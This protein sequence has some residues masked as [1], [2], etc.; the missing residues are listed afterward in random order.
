MKS[1]LSL[2]YVCFAEKCYLCNFNSKL[3]ENIA[4][5]KGSPILFDD[6]LRLSVKGIFSNLD[7]S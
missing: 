5:H 2:I 7:N 3:G 6:I 4:L 1:I